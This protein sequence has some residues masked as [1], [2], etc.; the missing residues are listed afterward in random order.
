METDLSK[1]QAD[2][3][4]MEARYARLRRAYRRW[5]AFCVVG[6]ALTL[7]SLFKLFG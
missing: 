4:E 3:S 5:L 7:R 1:L 2:I 6:G